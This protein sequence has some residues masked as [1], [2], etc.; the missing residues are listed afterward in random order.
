ME[1]DRAP[2]ASVEDPSRP[3]PAVRFDDG[4]DPDV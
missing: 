3:I 2:T 4:G 1:S